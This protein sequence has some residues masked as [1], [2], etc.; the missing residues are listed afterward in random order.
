MLTTIW[1]FLSHTPWWVYLIFV[2]C[3]IIGVKCSKPG[4]APLWKMFI[5]PIVFG[6]LSIHTLL[7]SLSINPF[8]LGVYL[9]SLVVG[10]LLGA[11]QMA[12]YKIEVDAK[13]RLLKIP[14]TWSIFIII[15]IIF[16]SKYYF[17]YELA[18]DPKL[19]NNTGFEVAL[20]FVSSVTTGLFIGK[21]IYC[22]IRMAKGPSVDLTK[23]K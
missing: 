15:M 21:V 22:L 13:H 8:V 6:Y 12:S 23:K 10:I 7:T 11:W 18:L 16:I 19:V 1:Q 4:V 5:M 9:A 17:G 14:G 20:L 3:L 2:Y